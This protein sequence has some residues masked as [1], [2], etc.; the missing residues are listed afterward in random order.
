MVDC[1]VAFLH[2]SIRVCNIRLR[3]ISKSNKIHQK[4]AL[5]QKDLLF[6]LYIC[7]SMLCDKHKKTYFIMIFLLEANPY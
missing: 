6:D 1:P 2:L 3:N 4:S 5:Q 7:Q